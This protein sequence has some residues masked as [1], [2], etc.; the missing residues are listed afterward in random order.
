MGAELE[1]NIYGIAKEGH[2]VK[3][4]KYR[5]VRN[6]NMKSAEEFEKEDV[7]KVIKELEKLAE[8]VGARR[9][10]YHE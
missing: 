10:K 1:L 8:S 3:F 7:S 9:G 5:V 2:I 6:S 4:T